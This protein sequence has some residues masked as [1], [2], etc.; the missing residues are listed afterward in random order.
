MQFN[1]HRCAKP[2]DFEKPRWR[3]FAIRDFTSI[4]K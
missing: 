1:F 3:G 2:P 4:I